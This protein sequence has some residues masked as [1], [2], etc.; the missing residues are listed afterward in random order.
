M[1]RRAHKLADPRRGTGQFVSTRCPT[2]EIEVR[3]TAL[4]K[5]PSRR[6]IPTMPS[7]PSDVIG[8]GDSDRRVDGLVQSGRYG[9]SPFDPRRRPAPKVD[10]W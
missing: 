6:T 7:D 4:F 2:S 3:F 10:T 1:S 9:S 8:R 5:P